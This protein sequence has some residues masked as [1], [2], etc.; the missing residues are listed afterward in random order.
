MTDE[1]RQAFLDMHNAYRSMIAKGLA[2]D[3]VGGFAP[4]AARMMKM[5]YDCDVEQ[6]MMEWAK[7]C[8]TWQAPSSARKGY[9]QNRFSIRP[10]EPNK[11]IVAEKAVNNWFGQLAQKGVPQENMLN[12]NVFYRGVWYYTQLAWQWSY[13]LGCAVVDCNGFTYAGCEYN[14]SSLVAKGKAKNGT[15]GGFAPKAARMLKMSYD[16]AAE[17]SV[18]SWI[19]NCI[20]KHNPGSDRPGYGQSLWSGSGSLFKANMTELAVW[21]VHSWY[22]ELPTH[23]A[24]ADNI[25]TWAVFNTGI[26]HYTALAWQ[27]THRIGC[28]VVYCK[29]WVITGCEYNPPGD[30]IGSII[31]EM[32]DPCV[33]DADC[34]CTGCKCSQ[35]EALCIPPSS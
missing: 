9:G 24:P 4:K 3:P 17:A 22:N 19:K 18:M 21:S 32:G 25:L 30:V 8:Q 35:E 11:T 27:N 12:L 20:F 15:H 23:G 13:Q 26:G 29:G 34:K 28:G 14:P 7:T 10:I 1:A 31:Y 33:T 6:T 16:C 5:I 2:K